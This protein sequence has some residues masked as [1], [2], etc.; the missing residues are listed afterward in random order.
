MFRARTF[1]WLAIGCL[2][3]PLIAPPAGAL[4]AKP[5]KTDWPQWRGQAR[6]GLSTDTGLLKEWPEEGPPLLWKTPGIGRGWSSVAVSNGRVYPVGDKDPD[7]FVFAIDANTGKPLWSSRIG[8]SLDDGPRS[9]PTIDGK[10]LYVISPHGEVVCLETAKGKERWRKHLQNDLEGSDTPS[11]KFCE[12]PLVDGDRLIVTPGSRS[13]GLVALNKLTGKLIWKA[14]LPEFGNQGMDQAGYSSVVISNGAGVKQYVQLVGRGVVGIRAEDGQFL[15]GYN[16][17]ANGTANIPT[18]IVKDDYVFCST[19]YGAGS[20]LLKLKRE[21]SGVTA[22]EVYFLPGD[23]L[24]NHH[25]GMVLVGDHIYCGHGHNNGFPVCLEMVSGQFAWK[26]G[27]G[28]GSESAAV[29]YADGHLYFRYQDGMMALIEATPEGYREKG[30]FQIPDCS[31]PSWSQ[32]VVA[33]GKLYLREQ[34]NLLCYNL[35]AR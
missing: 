18:P 17:V 8:A 15:W 14:P 26:Q 22:D 1:A 32:P 16:R 4:A 13:A 30:T 11:W 33:G 34:D 25:G 35:K 3:L 19:G 10:L 12:S 6:D 31:S 2:S 28:P 27:R 21:G 5:S 23:E 29:I 24:Q 9:T 7:E 20:A